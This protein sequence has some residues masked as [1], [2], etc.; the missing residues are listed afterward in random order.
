MMFD[1][2]VTEIVTM[3]S[4]LDGQQVT[5]AK[6]AMWLQALDGCS[7]EECVQAIVPAYREATNGFITAKG[8]WD[9]VRRARSQPDSSDRVLEEADWRSDPQPVCEEHNLRILECLDC[10]S[11]IFVQADHMSVDDR[12][13]WA[14]ANVYKPKEAWA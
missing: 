11:L 14:M 7:Y 13:S 5:E 8:I 6:V 3:C 12:H 2:Q 4:A 10:C 9:V 1:T